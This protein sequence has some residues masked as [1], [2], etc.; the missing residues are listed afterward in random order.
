M[1]DKCRGGVRARQTVQRRDVEA[2]E[3]PVDLV[4]DGVLILSAA[5]SSSQWRDHPPGGRCAM[6][7]FLAACSSLLPVAWSPDGVLVQKIS[8][9]PT[10]CEGTSFCCPAH[11][12]N[13]YGVKCCMLRACCTTLGRCLMKR[14]SQHHSDFP[15][16]L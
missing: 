4:L 15:I 13:F 12:E 9:G 1:R 16:F 14:S 11:S 8:S 3:E 2:V 5:C 6:L 7:V 10:S